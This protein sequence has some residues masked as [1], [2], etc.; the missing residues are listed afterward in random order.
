MA[1]R[2]CICWLRIRIW[3]WMLLS[4]FLLALILISYGRYL[5]FLLA[6][7]H[8]GLVSLHEMDTLPSWSYLDFLP[9]LDLRACR[10]PAILTELALLNWV[11]R[12]FSPLIRYAISFWCVKPGAKSYLSFFATAGPSVASSF[13]WSYCACLSFIYRSDSDPSFLGVTSAEYSS[14]GKVHLTS[15]RSSKR[16]GN[17]FFLTLLDFSLKPSWVLILIWK[18]KTTGRGWCLWRGPIGNEYYRRSPVSLKK[19][20]MTALNGIFLF[21]TKI[22]SFRGRSQQQARA[23][24]RGVVP[25]KENIGPVSQ[26]RS[27]HRWNDWSLSTGRPDHHS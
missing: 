8:L 1:V 12:L 25:T 21:W 18:V 9:F 27:F 14:R 16:G 19:W 13:R 2:W 7:S 3:M 11:N 5:S 6:F 20:G 4:Y 17:D 23:I 10:L 26:V 15:K 22:I 24:G